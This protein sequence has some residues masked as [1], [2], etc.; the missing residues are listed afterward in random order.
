MKTNNYVSS[1]PNILNG[2]PIVAGTRIPIS[3]ILYLLSQGYTVNKIKEEYPQLSVRKISE[4][5]ATIAQQAE[6]GAFLLA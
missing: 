1:N 4:I 2:M 3:R 5:I 6:K